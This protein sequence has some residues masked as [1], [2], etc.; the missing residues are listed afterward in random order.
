MRNRHSSRRTGSTVSHAAR[1]AASS[2]VLTSGWPARTV[3]M[4]S[5]VGRSKSVSTSRTLAVSVAVLMMI[6]TGGRSDLA[7]T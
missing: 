7:T 4:T 2:E 5:S 1:H 3:V 6:A